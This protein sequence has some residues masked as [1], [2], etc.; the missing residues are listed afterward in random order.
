MSKWKHTDNNDWNTTAYIW[1]KII[2]FMPKDK[3][4]WCPFYNDGYCKKYLEQ[5]GFNIIHNDEDFWGE[6]YDDV[7]VI[8]NPPYKIKGVVKIKE[9]IMLRLLDYKKPF[10]L[11]LPSTTIQTQY[12]KNLQDKY[13]KFQLCIPKEKYNFERFE[14]DKTK[15]LFYTLWV[16]WNM[17]L[18][19]DINII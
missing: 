7:V 13:G 5:Q 15:C 3:Q 14:G 11:L 6:M 19:N 18:T 2:P 16:C 9:L 8:D 1:D 4:I 10:M 17:N 12:F